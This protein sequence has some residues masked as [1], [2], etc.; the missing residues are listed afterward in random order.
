VVAQAVRWVRPGQPELLGG[1]TGMEQTVVVG[2]SAQS[3]AGYLAD[4]K[5]GRHPVMWRCGR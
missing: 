4:A 3:A 2:A 1:R 5:G